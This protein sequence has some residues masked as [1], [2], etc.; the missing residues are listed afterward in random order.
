M[1]TAK[2]KIAYLRGLLEGGNLYGKDPGDGI[3]WDQLLDIL[4]DMAVAINALSANQDELT[5]YV[6]AIDSDLMDLEDEVYADADDDDDDWVE[7]EC[8]ECG[9]P[10]TFEQ[11]F[12]Y[13]DDVQIT[14]PECGGVVYQ[15]ENFQDFDDLLD[16]EDEDDEDEE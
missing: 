12:L 13:D 6:E 10:V 11:G 9:E 5:E 8:P 3:L 2:E 14:C 4:D 15:G 16:Y 1:K 7:I